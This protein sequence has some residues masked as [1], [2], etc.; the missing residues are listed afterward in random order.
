MVMEEIEELFTGKLIPIKDHVFQGTKTKSDAAVLILF[1]KRN[2]EWNIVYTRRTKG[3][4]TH[5]GEVSFPGGAF[6]DNDESLVQTA[7][8]EAREEI[9][10]D[11]SCVKILGGLSPFRTISDY[12]V[13]PFIGILTCENSFVPNP[14]EVERIFLIP[15]KWLMDE[16][17]YFEE[18]HLIDSHTIKNVV[19]YNDYDGEHLWGLS[20]RITLDALAKI[21]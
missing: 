11:P 15:M 4:R 21:K 14:E 16:K 6:E 8:R 13:Y 17:N 3:V 10:I 19:H 1:V 2:Q 7:L 12:Y 5:Q 20:A 18:D 9:G